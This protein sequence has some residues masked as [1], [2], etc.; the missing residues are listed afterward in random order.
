ME[1]KISVIIPTYHQH[2]ALDL[3]LRS[4]IEGQQNKNQIIV[5][6][7]GYWQPNEEI[8][9]KYANNIDIL[10]LEEN[11]GMMRAMNLGT[12][13]AENELILHVHDDNVF[14]LRW[15]ILLKNSYKINSVLTPN[16]IEPRPSMFKQFHIKDLGTKPSE[17][18]LDTFWEY[19]EKISIFENI[20][21]FDENGSTFPF[22]MEKMDYLRIGGMDESY[23]GPWVVDWEFFMKC[24]MTGMN[25]IRTYNCHFYHFGSLATTSPEKQQLEQQCHDFAM[26]KWKTNIKHNSE[27]NDKFL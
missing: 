23:P 18:D 24:K 27:N 21:D 5:V 9:K 22:M 19:E 2:E 1:N 25:M 16:Q 6:E 15:D 20:N 14:P 26:Y 10:R 12:Y 4:A 3:C 11:V 17:F 7:N 8:F 13:N